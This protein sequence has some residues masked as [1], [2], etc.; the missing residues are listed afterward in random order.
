MDSQPRCEAIL[1]GREEVEFCLCLT[2]TNT[3]YS[4]EIHYMIVYVLNH[5]GLPLMPCSP[6]KARILLRDEKAKVVSTVPFKIKLLYPSSGYKQPIV[7]GMDSGSKTIGCAAISNGKVLYQSEVNLRND[8]SS[9]MERRSTYR[10]T[11]RSRKCRYRKA[12]FLNRR[13]S[14]KSN[15]LPPSIK[16]K[17]D[18][19]LREKKQVEAL[20]PVSQWNVETASFDIHKI[21]NPSVSGK[22]YQNGDLKGFYNIKAFILH[23]DNYK[24]KS[25]QKVKHSDKLHVHHVIFKSKGGSDTPSNL[26]TLCEK[27]HNDLHNGTFEIKGKKSTTKHATEIGIIKSQLL[28]VWNFNETFGYETKYKREQILK[29]PKSHSNDAIAICCDDD[30][31]VELNN[32]I[33]YKRHVSSGDYQQNKGVRSE[34]KIPT[35][36][37]FGLRKHDFIQTEKGSGFVKGK[38]SSGYFAI[39]TIFGETVSNSCNVKR[40]VLRLRAR[41]TTIIEIKE[42]GNSSRR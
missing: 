21:T 26:I 11:R 7:A 38:R 8:V 13:N 27:C 6:R 40:N 19:H 42:V 31:I 9:K 41:K 29:L 4:K 25:S 33:I 18:S 35:G 39:E 23:R 1:S 5:K 30:Q 24:C 34:K 36:K 17:V 15:R 28:K 32:L 22:D 37:L 12:R 3:H 16:S 20:L 2:Q 10:R 14:I